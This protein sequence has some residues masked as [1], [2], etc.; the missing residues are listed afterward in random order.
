MKVAWFGAIYERMHTGIV[1]HPYYVGA[2]QLPE[3][4]GFDFVFVAID[5]AKA[6]KVILPGLIAM[7]VPFIDVGIDVALDKTGALR[8]I[9]RFTVGTPGTELA[10][11]SSSCSSRW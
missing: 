8:G 7:K 3:F 1:R 9:C 4:T 11:S 10:S 5:D 6:R 2:E